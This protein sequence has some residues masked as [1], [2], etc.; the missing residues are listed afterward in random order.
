MHES[1]YANISWYVYIAKVMMYY[2]YSRSILYVAHFFQFDVGF[3]SSGYFFKHV[4]RI[5]N[6]SDV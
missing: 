4:S 2:V 6:K 3:S 1:F 5:C